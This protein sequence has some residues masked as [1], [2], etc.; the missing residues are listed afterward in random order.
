MIDRFNELLGIDEQLQT[1]YELLPNP[2]KVLA[3]SNM[4]LEEYYNLLVDAHIASCVQSRKAGV[5]SL[6]WD[7]DREL[8]P[9][10]ESKFIK[11]LF[12][13]IKIEDVIR[14]MLDGVLYGYKPMEIYWKK[15]FGIEI[16][17]N[18]FDRDFIIPD[19]VVG[20]PP[21]WY[22]FDNDHQLHFI[23]HATGLTKAVHPRKYILVQHE[24]TGDN[25][26]GNG[27][28]KQCFWPYQFKKGGFKGWTSYSEK[29]GQPYV[30]MV[31]SNA[32]ELLSQALKLRGGN[33]IAIDV[34]ANAETEFKVVDPSSS[35]SSELYKSLMHF[36]N[37]EIS[38]AILSQTLST[39]Q[40]DTGS[41]AM[42]QSHMEVRKEVVDSDARL[43]EQYLNQFIRWI[44]EFNFP[45]TDHIPEF[46][47]YEEEDVN[48]QLAER[49]S[50]LLAA[51]GIKFTQKYYANRY[52]FKPDEFEI[53]ENPQPQYN[54]FSEQSYEEEL[55]DRFKKENDKVIKEMMK[56]TMQG[57]SFEEIERSIT[58]A[59]PDV[60]IDTVTA[61]FTEAMLA[62]NLTGQLKGG[63]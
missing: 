32:R 20:K 47:L 46:G 43:I 7:I 8:P 44:I 13:K 14:E 27:V 34:V 62:G 40:S 1:W 29:F 42:S 41:Y 45:D 23:D 17:G 5:R 24:A 9:T 39:E 61:L 11:S 22:S 50:K 59:F 58:K 3:K 12:R 15:S 26:Y 4:G 49:D 63:E 30:Y 48:M 28:L 38:K 51:G 2:D 57:N 25:P 35:N 33:L 21:H 10:Y 52:G 6:E 16:D 31:G 60:N 56:L 55:E 54:Q 18:K 53:I 37:T 19:A 36:C